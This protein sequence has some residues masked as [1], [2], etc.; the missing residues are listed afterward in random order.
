MQQHQMQKQAATMQKNNNNTHDHTHEHSHN[1]SHENCSHDHSHENCSHDHSN[2]NNTNNSNKSYPIDPNQQKKWIE[3]LNSSNGQQNLIE[4]SSRLQIAKSTVEN[5]VLN[6]DVETKL[7]YFENYSAEV[8]ILLKSSSIP[9]ASDTTEAAI[10][11]IEIFNQLPPIELEKIMRLQ[12]IVLSNMK[13]EIAEVQGRIDTITKNETF[14]NMKKNM[15]GTPPLGS[16]VYPA[17]ESNNLEH[18]NHGHSHDHA[19]S[20]F[21]DDNQDPRLYYRNNN[22]DITKGKVETMDR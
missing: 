21:I 4:L 18:F 5:E 2:D 3:Y 8:P 10:A 20:N 19:I 6:W 9:Y 12:T 11:R 16:A 17:H 14:L 1:H 15:M 7:N 22:V 13:S